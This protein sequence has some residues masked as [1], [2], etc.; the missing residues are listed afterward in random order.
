MHF[1]Y[2]VS[3]QDI[4]YFF[5]LFVF[6]LKNPH[7]V[8]LSWPKIVDAWFAFSSALLSPFPFFQHP[9]SSQS[10]LGVCTLN[11]R[12]K[13]HWKIQHCL[14]WY[15]PQN[16]QL[17]VQLVLFVNRARAWIDRYRLAPSPFC[18]IWSS[19]LCRTI[20]MEQGKKERLLMAFLC[21]C[22]KDFQ[23]QTRNAFKTTLF[24]AAVICRWAMCIMERLG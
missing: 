2:L 22:W 11:S 13:N 19:R 24:L 5:F 1:I 23:L 16:K 8:E 10:L 15:F 20:C 9:Y 6:L 21:W 14:V 3:I 18:C 12:Q 4:Y 17:T 7:P